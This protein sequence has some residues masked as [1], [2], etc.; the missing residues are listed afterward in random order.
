MLSLRRPNVRKIAL[1][2]H[3]TEL[4]YKWFYLGAL[5]GVDKDRVSIACEGVSGTD[6]ELLFVLWK[7]LFPPFLGGTRFH[8][9]RD[10]WLLAIDEG[11]HSAIRTRTPVQCG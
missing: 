6:A 5:R 9:S 2:A 11:K 8:E 10:E 7:R 3:P 4:F 1:V